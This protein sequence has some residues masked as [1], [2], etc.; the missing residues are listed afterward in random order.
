MKKKILAIYL[1]LLSW[2]VYDSLIKLI[3]GFPVNLVIFF[4]VSF[5]LFALFWI[6]TTWKE[7]R[8]K[9]DK[10]ILAALSLPL[11]MRVIL[12]IFAVGKDRAGYNALVSNH[13][14]DTVTW[15]TLVIVLVIV[16][17]TE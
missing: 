8:H 6:Y 11:V 4:Y 13:Y 1:L 14:I 9:K 3:D 10:R 12:N 17:C 7:V 15:T 16:L 2:A 5:Y